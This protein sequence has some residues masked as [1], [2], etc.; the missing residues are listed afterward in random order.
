MGV[1]QRRLLLP[2]LYKPFFTQEVLPSSAASISWCFSREVFIDGPGKEVSAISYI[3]NPQS[4]I[5]LSSQRG[6]YR[7]FLYLECTT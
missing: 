4:V 1:S 3:S 7:Y 5:I 6:L 2:W